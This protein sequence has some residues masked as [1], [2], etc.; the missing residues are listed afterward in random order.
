MPA[1]MKS[2]PRPAPT[3][4][5][6]MPV[7]FARERAGTQQDAELICG[8]DREVAGD[9]PLPTD[10]GLADDRCG[11]DFIVQHDGEWTADILLGRGVA[12][13]R[14]PMPLKVKETMGSPERCSNPA[15]ASVRSDPST[16][17][18]L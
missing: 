18:C 14:A 2:A 1:R 17:T 7:S 5:C 11:D 9:L 13:L 10:D 3:V 6:W 15:L 4:R 16:S 12:N 8:F